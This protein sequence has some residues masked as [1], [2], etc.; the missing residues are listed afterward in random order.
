MRQHAHSANAPFCL[1]NL[2]GEESPLPLAAN[3]DRLAPVRLLRSAYAY[4]S[5]V[6][7]V[8]LVSVIML[9]VVMVLVIVR[10]VVGEEL[11]L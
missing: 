2:N 1:G 4:R 6:M 9:M 7:I 11:V 3:F 5:V 8:L 10:L